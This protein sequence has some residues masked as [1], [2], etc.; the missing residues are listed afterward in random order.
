MPSMNRYRHDSSHRDVCWRASIIRPAAGALFA[1]LIVVSASVHAATGGAV[2]T[3]LVGR[4]F[5][6]LKTTLTMTA[7]THPGA[8]P[9][10]AVRAMRLDELDAEWA[11]MVADIALSCEVG[12]GIEDEPDAN[13]TV[14][15]KLRPKA[16]HFGGAPVVEIRMSDS[17]WGNDYQYVLDA[18]FGSAR[19]RL[20]TAIRA[21]CLKNSD[22]AADAPDTV[23]RIQGDGVHGGLY[24][25]T[26]EGGGLWLHPD[27]DNP[28]RTIFA[29]AWSE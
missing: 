6:S 20:S 24:I 9:C 12:Q 4:P 3:D 17:A 16:A 27:P 2:G 7:E 28:R 1:L 5:P 22:A 15:A 21:H 13:T 14:V 19:Q 29:S 25:D 11:P 23:C 8:S 18:R 26:G 10:D